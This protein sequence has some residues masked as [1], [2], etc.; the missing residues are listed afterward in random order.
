MQEII[1]L[2]L[3]LTAIANAGEQVSYAPSKVV[4][5]ISTPD[6]EALGH[7]FDRVNM[8]QNV[9]Q[10]DPFEAS[11]VLVIHEGAIP[12]FSAKDKAIQ[13]ELMQRARGLSMGEIIKFRV[14]KASAAMQ[15]FK[16][17]D[18]QDFV[19]MVP[20]ADAEIVKLQQEGYAY[21]R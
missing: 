11:I 1:I 4:Y 12:L 16:K 2:L 18:L 17:N 5:D 8:L 13:R 19:L 9:Y 20:M 3:A 6:P 10:N 21:L 14:C 7:I 15:G